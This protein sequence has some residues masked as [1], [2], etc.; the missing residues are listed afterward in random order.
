MLQLQANMILLTSALLVLKV[1]A[2]EEIE[3]MT[4]Y[5]VLM[6]PSYRLKVLKLHIGFEDG[7]LTFEEQFSIDPSPVQ[8]VHIDRVL[9]YVM[10]HL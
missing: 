1:E 10:G 2:G 5:G 8:A 4:S 6:G 3:H 9:D 7:T